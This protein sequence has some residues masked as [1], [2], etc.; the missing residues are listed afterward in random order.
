MEIFIKSKL[1]SKLIN[2]K[3]LNIMA[4]NILPLAAMEKLLKKV[5]KNS[6]NTLDPQ[7]MRFL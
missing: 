2:L 6:K 1:P 7:A 3:E 5:E 4:R